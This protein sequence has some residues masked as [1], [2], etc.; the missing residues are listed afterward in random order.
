[1]I[2]YKNSDE[3]LN[4][5]YSTKGTIRKDIE[6]NKGEETKVEVKKEIKEPIKKNNMI[7]LQTE[8]YTLTSQDN[9]YR[10]TLKIDF[11]EASF[12]LYKED[13]TIDFVWSHSSK[14]TIGLIDLIK[15]AQVFAL[16][17]IADVCEL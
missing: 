3:E 8:N 1:M 2:E 13:G 9:Q 4:S 11:E 14:D 16:E 10:I 6:K 5:L 17:R 7:V 15:E 12:S